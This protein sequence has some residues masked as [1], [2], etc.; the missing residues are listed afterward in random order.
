MS[1]GAW[2]F[3]SGKKHP[4]ESEEFSQS[5]EY[6]GVIGVPGYGPFQ[7]KGVQ[8]FQVWLKFSIF[9]INGALFPPHVSPPLHPLIPYG[10]PKTAGINRDIT[11]KL[12][13]NVLLRITGSGTEGN[14][15]NLIN[16][17]TLT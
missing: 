14:T 9:K 5:R 13:T 10:F 15:E 2:G 8:G 7:G 17:N 1:V 6:I 11:L 16:I 12:D 4:K 3:A